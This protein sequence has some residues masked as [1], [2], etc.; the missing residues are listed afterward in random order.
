MTVIL[1]GTLTHAVAVAVA[2]HL[3]ARKREQLDLEKREA[4]GK[5]EPI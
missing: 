1:T 2:V 3:Q 5:M 4:I